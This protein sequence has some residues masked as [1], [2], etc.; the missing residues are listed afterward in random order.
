MI[1]DFGSRYQLECLVREGKPSM[2]LVGQVDTVNCHSSGSGYTFTYLNT[3]FLSHV[4]LNLSNDIV[5]KTY[6]EFVDGDEV[7]IT[8]RV[9][10]KQRFRRKIYVYFNLKSKE[11]GY[12]LD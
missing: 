2:K 4:L 5:I 10:D 12:E 8:F 7:L 3:G 1:I 9:V 6:D 11:V